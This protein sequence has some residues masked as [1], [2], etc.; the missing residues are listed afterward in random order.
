MLQI[1]DIAGR[2]DETGFDRE[3]NGLLLWGEGLSDVLLLREERF[4]QMN[5]SIE[6]KFEKFLKQA[7][8]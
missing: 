3:S 5:G 7:F 2:K 4:Q 8:F 1:G 6:G